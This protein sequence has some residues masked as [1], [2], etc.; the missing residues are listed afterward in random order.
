VTEALY[1]ELDRI[2]AAR[3]RSDM[4]PTIAAFEAIFRQHPD[5]ARVKYELGGAYDTAGEETRAAEL[6]ESALQTGLAGDL[7]RRCLLQ[8]G[9]T[10]RNL[11]RFDESIEVFDRARAEYPD[12]VFA[13]LTRHAAGH[14]H[15]AFADLL[16]VVAA[17]TDAAD[18]DRYRP[19][20]R[21]NADYLRGLDAP[22]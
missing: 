3:D 12:A 22:S 10:L 13:A 14:T 7:R 8:Y 9:S 15:T 5:D 11:E 17:R 1:A 21:A 18:L 20:L 4:A 2:F 6:Y 16:D 19:A